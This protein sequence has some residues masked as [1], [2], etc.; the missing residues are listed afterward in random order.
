VK[1][2]RV[3]VSNHSRI[4]DLNIE[5]RD[6][7]VLVG[8]NNVGKSAFLR[9]LDL[10]LGTST[11]QL[12]QRIS[13]GD[14]REP[15]EPLEILA[16]LS[17]LSKDGAALFPDELDTETG[18]LTIKLVAN[19]DTA[20][21]LSVART[22]PEGGTQRQ[23]S[24]E[25]VAGIGWRLLAAT[26]L[27]RDLRED[28][29]NAVDEILQSLEL[30]SE[31]ADFDA[32]V[33]ALR[34]KLQSSDVLETLRG[35]LA[36]QLSRA[37]P[38][39]VKKDDLVFLPGAAT[40]DDVLNGVS[41]QVL[42]G[43][44]PRS[45]TDQSDGT[46]ALYVIALYDLV[47]ASAN[48]VAID[49]PE[50]HLHPTSQRSLATLLL[51]GANQK[52]L[53]THSPDFVG[54]FSPDCIVAMS[55]GG[56]CV[57]PK[58]SFLSDDERTRVRWWVRDKLEPLTAR[59]VIAV[60]GISDRII[61]QRASEAMG[62]NLDRLGVSVIETGGSGDMAAMIKLFGPDG[63]QVPMSLMIDEDARDA[64]ADSFGVAA[65]DLET[66]GVWICAPDLEAEYVSA[67]G[68]VAVWEAIEKS[69]LFSANQ[70]SNCAQTGPNGTRTLDDVAGFC[71]RKNYKVSAALAVAPDITPEAAVGLTAIGGLIGAI[72]L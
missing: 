33:E 35:S 3:A 21:N 70:R 37:L 71:R 50:I 57:Q 27:S 24:R 40:D 15:A 31:Q 53:A 22:A 49:E 43:G 36:S 26:G 42:D 48:L 39:P 54:M 32:L 52:V 30:G 38:S 63:F 45:L 61:L 55:R 59:H 41:L 16:E 64:T 13:P 68:P 67:L 20:E 56:A 28:R 69:G 11:A 6:H 4:V 44:K 9:C 58:V 72:N 14:F 62:R 2:K 46:R 12:Y 10:L 34:A 1:L 25:Q 23:L 18:T 5:V 29:R 65:T 8:P 17:E 47:S 7:L 51:A 19:L 66:K 60:E